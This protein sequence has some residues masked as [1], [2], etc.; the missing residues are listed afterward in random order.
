MT[1]CTT[2]VLFDS[3]DSIS[4]LRDP[5]NEDW[6]AVV[7]AIDGELYDLVASRYYLA[8]SHFRR[9]PRRASLPGQI[10]LTASSREQ[11]F[12]GM[13]VVLKQ[14]KMSEKPAEGQEKVAIFVEAG[15]DRKDESL[16][17]ALRDFS[18]RP[19]SL[20]EV[21]RGA[22]RPP[23]DALCL[24]RAFLTAPLLEVGDSPT[25]VHRLLH[26]NPTYARQCG[27]SGPRAKG[28][29][30]S[31]RL[32]SLATCA[33][34]GEV[35]T[36]YGLW[37]LA[38]IE[39]VHENLENRTVTIED[40]LSFDTTHV[41]ANS[42]CG[43]VVPTEA[44]TEEEAKEGAKERP[45]GTTDIDPKTGKKKKHRK[46]PR[47]R[48]KCSCGKRQ[49]DQCEHPWV[50]T[51]HGAAVVVKG[52]TRVYWAHKASIVCFGDSEVPFDIRTC[53]YAAESDGKTL[54]PHLKL[55]ERDFPE[56]VEWLL[57]VLADDAYQGNAAA[58]S[59][60]GQN[61][62][63]I[64]PVHPSN[65]SKAKLAATLEG[66]DH[67][68]PTGIPVCQANH[69]FVMLGRDLSYERYIWAAPQ[70]E[71]GR[72]VCLGCSHAP[73]CLAKGERRHIRVDRAD[74][75]QI[76]WEH[77]QH[78][79]RDRTRYGKRTG[80][81]RAIKRIKVDLKGELLT[82]RDG[83]RVQAHFDRKLLL[84]HLLLKADASG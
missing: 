47:M 11:A 52:P 72:S 31:R 22:G 20:R 18:K 8:L 75:P 83:P 12:Q 17:E 56:V 64:V 10:N 35:M 61:A 27:F 62:R 36:R 76:D 80:I 55:V 5:V 48:K 54:I 15:P 69:H 3:T 16:P 24:M 34:F 25:A 49:W 4:V 1:H 45:V 84:L 77:P 63:L 39:Q 13:L 41:E 79:N 30:T 68:T 53:Q 65:Q 23:C 46:V 71:A 82:H 42:H 66:I 59:G 60:F 21:L 74:F 70:E 58:V 73:M 81:E 44:A 19:P 32:P 67:F 26:S 43:N 2:P 51:D 7:R 38:R 40:T 78:L 50:P 33:E 9:Q 57:Y 6:I 37:Q 28:D 29:I 14:R